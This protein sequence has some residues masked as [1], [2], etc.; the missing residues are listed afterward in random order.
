MTDTRYNN[1]KLSGA[2]KKGC[3]KTYRFPTALF[4]GGKKPRS[5]PPALFH[6]RK[7]LLSVA[8]TCEIKISEALGTENSIDYVVVFLEEI[9]EDFA[10]L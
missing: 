4:N 8:G 5:V 1:R 10:C 2:Q 6:S 7:Y 9:A 3:K